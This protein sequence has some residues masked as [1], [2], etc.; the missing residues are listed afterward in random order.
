M[1]LRIDA[2]R[3]GAMLD[4]VSTL[5]DAKVDDTDITAGDD[6]VADL[7]GAIRRYNVLLGI[8]CGKG[9]IAGPPCGEIYAPR[10]F[11]PPPSSRQLRDE[12][13]D[14]TTH[15][16]PFW[17]SVCAKLDNPAHATCQLE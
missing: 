16:Y 1:L 10:L 14:A 9:V 13:D 8:A 11:P 7:Q 12:V 17:T 6:I 4:Q 5:L 3:L 15:I 2:G